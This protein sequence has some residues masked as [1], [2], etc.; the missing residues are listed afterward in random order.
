M[1]LAINFRPVRRFSATGAAWGTNPLNRKPIEQPPDELKKAN[2][3]K[4]ANSRRKQYSRWFYATDIAEWMPDNY[5]YKKVAE[6]KKFKPFSVGDSNKIEAAFCSSRGGSSGNSTSKV[7]VNEDQLFEID[8]NS[9]LMAPIYW[10]GPIYAIRKGL[11]FDDDNNPFDEELTAE[12]ES[13][14]QK[15]RKNNKQNGSVKNKDVYNLS[16]GQT[17]VFTGEDS[18]YI[19]KE[20]IAGDL[21]LNMYRV[22]QSAPMPGSVHIKRGFTDP[23]ID[24]SSIEN[25][26]EN[27]VSKMLDL[28]LSQLFTKG[29]ISKEEEAQT[30]ND[31]M[32][33]EIEQDYSKEDSPKRKIDHLILCVHGIG[34]TLSASYQSVNFIHTINILR[35]NM[36]SV[37]NNNKNIQKLIDNKQLN[38]QVLPISW[39]NKVDFSTEKSI[40]DLNDKG[41][42]RLPSLMDLTIDEMKPLRN[43]LGSVLLDIL[44]YYEPNYKQQIIT[45]VITEANDIVARFKRE[46]PY[47]NGKI[48]FI[49]HSLGSA[50]TFDIL[51]EHSAQLNFEVEDYF[52]MGAPLGVFNL[53]KH[54]NIGSIGSGDRTNEKIGVPNCKNLYNIFN[55]Y[56]PIAYRIEPLIQPSFKLFKPESIPILIEDFNKYLINISEISENLTNKFKNEIINENVSKISKLLTKGGSTSAKTG[57]N[58]DSKTENDAAN[59]AD[60]TDKVVKIKKRKLDDNDFNKLRNLNFNARVDYELNQGYLN[61]NFMSSIKAHVHYFEDE[62]VAAFIVQEILKDRTPVKEKY[63][64]LYELQDK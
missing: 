32:K 26:I 57:V 50:I 56:D 46:N 38:I 43:L 58:N 7:S 8:I 13:F 25:S 1:K 40:S 33:L 19:I 11:W 15:F 24:T 62:N 54:K 5:N 41:E 4:Q 49:G 21:Q 63:V 52:A 36:K 29:F 30:T 28:E 23:A 10:E 59:S 53:L 2:E 61:L 37:F 3:P 14:Y 34:Q 6:P 55:P 35:K 51:S 44:L 27:S 20:L 60:V 64:N 48:S 47:F 39:R 17:L 9:R 16:G 18:G 31:V 12:I 22:L 42:E 45:Q